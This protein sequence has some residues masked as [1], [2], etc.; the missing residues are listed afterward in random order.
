MT[1]GVRGAVYFCVVC[2][3]LILACPYLQAP[4][5]GRIARPNKHAAICVTCSASD[6]MHVFF[7]FYHFRFASP[8]NAPSFGS[9]AN[10]SAAAPPSFG[11]L[12]Q[13]PSGFGAQTGA[14]SGFGSPGGEI[15]P[16]IHPSPDRSSRALSFQT[17][18]CFYC[19]SLYSCSRSRSRCSNTSS[20]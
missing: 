13:Q 14:F 4:V 12:A 9:L 5:P 7:F 1:D 2:C 17:Q 16:H 10:P 11:S 3:D 18:S 20:L 8:P 19:P 6:T 15:P